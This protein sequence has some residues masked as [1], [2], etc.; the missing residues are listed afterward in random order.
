MKGYNILYSR[1]KCPSKYSYLLV[2]NLIPLFSIIPIYF[3]GKRKKY[4]NC[5]T[6]K[7]VTRIDAVFIY[8]IEDNPM[9]NNKKLIKTL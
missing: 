8:I 5:L 3:N 9:F 6:Q 4:H 2:I 1:I 7:P